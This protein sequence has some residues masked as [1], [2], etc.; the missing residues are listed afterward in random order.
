MS[1]EVDRRKGAGTRVRVVPPAGSIPEPFSGSQ[2]VM[3]L[4]ITVQTLDSVNLYSCHDD[5]S[6]TSLPDP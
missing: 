1:L 4:Y 6:Q 5:I 3:K 2:G